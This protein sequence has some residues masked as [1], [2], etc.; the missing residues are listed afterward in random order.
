VSPRFLA[1]NTL[2]V[3]RKLAAPPNYFT[4][5]KQTAPSYIHTR[6]ARLDNAV[7]PQ[8][9]APELMILDAVNALNRAL[10]RHEERIL[11]H[12]MTPI[13]EP[14]FDNPPLFLLI[15]TKKELRALRRTID[16][17]PVESIRLTVHLEQVRK[18]W[19]RNLARAIRRGARRY[20]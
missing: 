4:P 5:P 19:M 10:F 13:G 8:P 6:S 7:A 3:K 16:L 20:G 11:G 2:T 12:G 14:H 9:T 1:S 15:Y 17:Y 18:R